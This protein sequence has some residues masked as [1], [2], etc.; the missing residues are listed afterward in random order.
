MA[1]TGSLPAWVQG[2]AEAYPMALPLETRLLYTS[3]TALGTSRAL[4]ALQRLHPPA[5]NSAGSAPVARIQRDKIQ[6]T[7]PTRA[8]L[9]REVT[10]SQ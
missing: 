6:V 7:T 8:P 10:R 9:P 2:L 5:P 4:H 3:L 1:C